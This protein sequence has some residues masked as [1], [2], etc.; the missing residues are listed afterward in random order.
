M[1]LHRRRRRRSTKNGPVVILASL[2]LSF[3]HAFSRN[4]VFL[5]MFWTPACAGVMGL[6]LF[7]KV[8]IF[9]IL[10]ICVRLRSSA[11]NYMVSGKKI[12]A[13][14]K[15]RMPVIPSSTKFA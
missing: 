12:T 3:R 1:K 10:F 11:A 7:A 5:N 14:S 8:S 6:W 15:R 4:P 9:L 2:H 13:V